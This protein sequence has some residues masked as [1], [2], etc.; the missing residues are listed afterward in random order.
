M[1]AIYQFP[2]PALE[3]SPAAVRASFPA[4]RTATGR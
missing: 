4:A 2:T 3:P 1:N